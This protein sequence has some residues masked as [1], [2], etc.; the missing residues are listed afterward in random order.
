MADAPCSHDGFVYL[1]VRILSLKLE[2]EATAFFCKVN[3]AGK[4]ER[5]SIQSGK[6]VSVNEFFAFKMNKD[7]FPSEELTISVNKSRGKIMTMLSFSS[8]LLGQRQKWAMQEVAKAA[9][10]S[11]G[12]VTIGEPFSLSFGAGELKVQFSFAPP[13]PADSSLKML[14]GTWNV[15]N[16]APHEDLTSWLQT[17]GGEQQLIVVGS[18][19]CD[20]DARKPHSSCD[21][22]FI[23]SLASSIGEEKYTKVFNAS[24]G[25]MRLAVFARLDVAAAV[26]GCESSTEATGVARVGTNKGGVAIGMNLWDTSFC[27]IN[28]HLAAHQDEVKTRNLDYSEIVAGIHLGQKGFHCTTQFDH[29][30]WMGDLNYRVEWGPC[31]K[32]KKANAEAVAEMQAKFSTLQGIEELL[33]YDQLIRVRESEEAFVGFSEGVITHPPTFKVERGH[34]Q[35][36]KDQRLPAWCDRVMWKTQPDGLSVQQTALDWAP[37]VLSSDHK[38]VLAKFVAGLRSLAPAATPAQFVWKVTELS[39]SGLSAADLSGSSD[40]YVAFSSALAAGAVKSGVQNQTLE[41]TWPS[42]DL[43][44]LR[45]LPTD[46]AHLSQNHVFV[47]VIDQDLLTE[48]DTIGQGS[49]SLAPFV[50]AAGKPVPFEL[51]LLNSGLPAGTLKGTAVLGPA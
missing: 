35:E 48:D 13:A 50:A 20:Y 45:F 38:P 11:S 6:E 1:G 10:A 43:P 49:L 26:S 27:F 34:E 37:K 21:D 47:N 51:K 19:E 41:P 17:D 25:Q 28:S 36:Y 22:D 12:G 24:L 7:K 16:K 42:A 18:Q 46:N 3:C 31:A 33:P 8:K 40:P 14:C 9:K 5:T 29:L 32:E 44:S 30:F 23:A 4:K 15:G 2:K 39:A